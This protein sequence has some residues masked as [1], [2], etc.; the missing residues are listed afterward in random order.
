M[1]K[2]LAIAL[3]LLMVA[4]LLPV[5]AMAE[6]TFKE[7]VYAA[8][9]SDIINLE[10]GSFTIP[11]GVDTGKTVPNKLIFAGNG[12]DKTTCVVEGITSGEST[13]TY[14]FDGGKEV[15]FQN[16]TID[17]GPASNFDGFVR[18]GNMTFVNCS[19]KG[20]GSHWGTGDVVFNN[21]TFQYPDSYNEWTYNLWLYSGNSFTF[22]GCT[23]ETKIGGG[24]ENNP[25]KGKFINVYNQGN[26]TTQVTVTANNCTFTTDV[27]DESVQANKTIFN[28]GN[29]S[30]WDIS[31]SG[32][33]TANAKAAVCEQT[34]SNLYG[35]MGDDG[36]NNSNNTG[37]KVKVENTSV[38]ENGNKLSNVPTPPE[39]EPTTPGTITIIVSD[40]ST[41]TTT[42]TEKPANPATGANDFVGAAAALAVV[43][44]L[45]MA[46]ASRKK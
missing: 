23:F 13:A 32:A 19:I 8:S 28:I 7:K 38:W 27:I 25:G 45:G 43:S 17:F 37:I 30:A 18:A 11:S 34:S 33:N 22:D 42:T 36:I 44:L 35:T 24:D 41:D 14:F 9:D 20:M 1:K 10:D 21:C 12:A 39:E 6:G 26:P 29:G 40:D 46:V 31:I 15:T 16:V 4:V 3:A 5:T 2:L